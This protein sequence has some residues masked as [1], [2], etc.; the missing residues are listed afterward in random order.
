MGGF[1]NVML[2]SRGGSKKREGK[3]EVTQP[4]WD[5]KSWHIREFFFLSDF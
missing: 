5:L 2:V 4:S 3:D 1:S